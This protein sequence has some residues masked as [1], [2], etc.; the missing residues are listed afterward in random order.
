LQD[1]VSSVKNVTDQGQ[2]SSMAA[3]PEP[4]SRILDDL[5]Q[6]HG[7]L[8]ILAGLMEIDLIQPA[9]EHTFK[10][11]TPDFQTWRSACIDRLWL[12]CVRS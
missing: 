12:G 2:P 11:H 10:L 6:I 8:M 3:I 5:D 1:D 4:E 9:S 7:F